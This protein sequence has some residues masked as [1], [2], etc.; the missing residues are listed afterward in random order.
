MPSSRRPL[1]LPRTLV[2]IAGAARSQTDRGAG[3][4]RS[5]DA[6]LR[7][8]RASRNTALLEAI[9]LN[10]LR[11]C[12]VIGLRQSDVDVKRM[13]IR[14]NCESPWMPLRTQDRGAWTSMVRQ[15]KRNPPFFPP[16]SR[17]TIWRI[18]RAAG[19]D[20]GL[21]KPMNSR[22]AR[23][24][25]GYMLGRTHDLPARTLAIA[26]GVKDPRSIERY[27]QP[28]SLDDLPRSPS[29]RRRRQS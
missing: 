2:D 3:S 14:R 4:A 25:L 22:R 10:G 17:V 1:L 27:L 23:R 5:P 11:I 18:L 21:R 7:V 13:L 15:Q 24:V 12:E 16:L 26:L 20:A 19:E 6:A 29:A 9:V 28:P 8:Q